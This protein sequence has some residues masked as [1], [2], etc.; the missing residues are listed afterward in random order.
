MVRMEVDPVHKLFR[1]IPKLV[2]VV[3]AVAS[4]LV[5]ASLASA[6]P[7]PTAPATT[8]TST[9]TAPGQRIDL[10]VL[11]LGGTGAEPSYLAW[12]AELQREGVPFEAIAATPG[13]TPIT[14]ASLSDT[15][16]GAI[17]EGKYQAVILATGG[18]VVCEAT[19]ASA[20]SSTEWSALESYEQTFNVRQISAYV[21]PGSTYGLNS[22]SVS[23]PLDGTVGS[24]TSDGNLAFPY[25]NGAV[26]IDTGTYGYQATPLAA[27]AT[28][29]SFDTLLTGPSNSA[30]VGVYTHPNGTQELVQTFDGN[31]GQLQSETLRHGELNWVTRGVYLG[32][33]RNYLAVNVDDVFLSDDSWDT[34]T[35]T[36]DYNP[37][38]AIRMTPADVDKAAAWSKQ[39]GITLGMLFN[40]GGSDQYAAEHAGSDPL[41]SEFKKDSADFY[42]LS[43]TYDHPNLD[44][45]TQAYTDTEFQSNTAWAKKDGFSTN[46]AEVVTGE[47]SGLANLV[48]G[49]PGTVDPPD[50]DSASVSPTGGAL[51]AGSYEYAVTDTSSNGES[52]PSET[53]AIPGGAAA[54][55]STTLTWQAVCHASGYKVYRRA[56]GVA[57]SWSLIASV[58]PPSPSFTNTGAVEV[59]FT[60]TTGPSAGEAATPPAINGATENPY[61][62]NPVFTAAL[63]ESAI[64]Y[65]GSDASKPYPSNPLEVNS[66][67]IPAGQTF[68]DGPAQAVPRY[69][70]N[71][72]YN[73]ATQAQ[74][75]D[76]YNALYLPPSLGGVCV[77]TA[78]TTCES[79]PATFAQIVESAATNMFGHVMGNDPRPHYFHQTNIAGEGILYNVLNTLL[80][81]YHQYFNSSAPIV[82][83]TESQSG[84]LL[85]EQQ[86]WS[87]ALAAG[88]VSGYLQGNQV[89]ITNTGTAISVP[90][91][92][93]TV[94]TLYGGIKSGWTS[95]PAGS[96]S[97]TTTAPSSAPAVTRVSPTSGPS[98]GGSTVTITGTGFLSGSTVKFGTVAATQV[99]VSSA[100]TITA[101]SPA[102]S[103]TVD[104]TVTNG[105]GTS[106]T[107]TADRF[108]YV[109][110]PQVT[111]LAPNTGSTLLGGITV[112]TG[113]GFTGASEV[114]FGSTRG[115]F[116]VLSD[117]MILAYA[118][119]HAAGAVDVTV[120]A[121][122][123]VSAISSADRFTFS[124]RL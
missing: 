123:G 103:G 60:D 79:A 62:Q 49:N 76:E 53:T 3:V 14:A 7:A 8:T 108:A 115:L 100:G 33:Q 45:A 65:F 84:A 57:N 114:D 19:C 46:P 111:G 75:V 69:P 30:L 2:Y 34:A 102:G 25:L 119:P 98:A 88:K 124:A 10:K 13:H 89:T 118:P 121:A 80:A 6:A 91:T 82:Q 11:L 51:P 112:I 122:S 71:I 113:K 70:E 22:P 74:E 77:N 86:A 48:P 81:E 23:G 106:A 116:A 41:L 83:L 104:V 99:T 110:P 120:H 21:Y 107:G 47:H 1:S 93:T 109:A 28:G 26:K 85:L 78:V 52:T 95:V 16:P 27:Q 72:Y 66:P 38:D 58:P 61:A 9:S 59:S 31:S 42:W 56:S 43:H 68:T 101:V 24:L 96:T 105:N 73:V 97:Y 50:L 20:L 87:N 32:D 5:A 64:K 39:N 94:G 35:H 4:C 29:A 15:L 18:L 92:G 90:V 67:Q 55:N 54:T 12:K 17:Q 36:T 40:G 44:C 37:A 117:T 63:T